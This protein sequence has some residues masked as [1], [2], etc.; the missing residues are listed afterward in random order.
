MTNTSSRDYGVFC[1]VLGSEDQFQYLCEFV[2]WVVYG[3][4][5]LLLESFCLA[6]CVLLDVEMGSVI[7]YYMPVMN[8]VVSSDEGNWSLCGL[9]CLADIICQLSYSVFVILFNYEYIP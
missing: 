4:I 8:G 1:G 5:K 6:I 2:S 7:C 3:H 9:L